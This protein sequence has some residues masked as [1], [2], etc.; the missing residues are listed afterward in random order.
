METFAVPSVKLLILKQKKFLKTFLCSVLNHQHHCCHGQQKSLILTSQNKSSLTHPGWENL[1][2]LVLWFKL[3]LIRNEA[4]ARWGLSWRLWNY[5][6]SKVSS[7][8]V[9]FTCRTKYS[10]AA[11]FLVCS[12]DFHWVSNLSF[13]SLWY[14]RN[15][16]LK[17]TLGLLAFFSLRFKPSWQ[18]ARSQETR[19]SIW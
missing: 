7:N 8:Y 12:F 18:E 9:G 19:P 16:K 13:P 6:S 2:W 15:M 17:T 1:E 14:N 4:T 5:N 10:P 11:S 3:R